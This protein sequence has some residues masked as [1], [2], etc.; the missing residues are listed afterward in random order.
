[1]KFYNKN[2]IVLALF[3]GSADAIRILTDNPGPPAVEA[4]A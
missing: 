4:L 3:L 1:M 2:A